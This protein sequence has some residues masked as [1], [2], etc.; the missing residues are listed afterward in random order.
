MSRITPAEADIPTRLALDAV[1]RQLGFV[2]HM[3]HALAANPK[4]LSAWL[5]LKNAMSTSLDAATARAAHTL[6]RKSTH[7]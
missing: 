1:A 3:H 4:A 5:D 7:E 2:P 6:S